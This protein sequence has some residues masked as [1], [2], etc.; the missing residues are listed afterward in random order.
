MEIVESNLKGYL[1]FNNNGFFVK[2]FKT[3]P[4]LVKINESERTVYK[5]NKSYEILGNLRDVSLSDSYKEYFKKLYPEKEFLIFLEYKRTKNTKTITSYLNYTNNWIKNNSGDKLF[6]IFL[7]DCIK[8]NELTKKEKVR[9][10][11]EEKRKNET[12]IVKSLLKD[13]VDNIV[14]KYGIKEYKN[15]GRYYFL[16]QKDLNKFIFEMLNKSVF[17]DLRNNNFKVNIKSHRG[18]L[19]LSS[20]LFTLDDLGIGDN[21]E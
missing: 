14:S 9:I 10:L 5:I 11:E 16:T 2:F 20:V 12:K 19:S 21:N 13:T 15:T 1:I 7:D 8:F 4:N 6:I 17:E 3:R 18:K